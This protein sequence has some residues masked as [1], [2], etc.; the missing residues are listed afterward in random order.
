MCVCVCVCEYVLSC[1]GY[2]AIMPTKR[3]RFTQF[4]VISHNAQDGHA[5]PKP[6]ATTP[7]IR[8]LTG[9]ESKV[10]TKKVKME[11]MPEN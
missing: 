9:K 6:I 4:I 5:Q 2:N 1:I 3:E 11:Q 10:N 8:L 7:S